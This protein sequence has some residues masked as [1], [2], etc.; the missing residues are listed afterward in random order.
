MKGAKSATRFFLRMAMMGAGAALAVDQPFTFE[1]A[2]GA[3][4]GGA[5][6]GKCLGQLGLGRQ[7]V[8]RLKESGGDIAQNCL[9]DLSV[10]RPAIIRASAELLSAPA[11]F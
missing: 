8:A 3:G 11:V 10:A 4:D 2:H 7:A 1:I 5:R 9:E 6:C